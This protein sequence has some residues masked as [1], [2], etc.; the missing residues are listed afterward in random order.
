ME[1]Y[2]SEIDD[3]PKKQF[4]TPSHTPN[5]FSLLEEEL[6]SSEV[7]MPVYARIFLRTPSYTSHWVYCAELE[8][9]VT[10]VII[11]KNVVYL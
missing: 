6:A 8:S 3:G 4:V 7:V 11:N 5:R 10:L 1:E 9:A 2:E